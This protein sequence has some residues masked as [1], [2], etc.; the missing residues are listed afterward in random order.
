[1]KTLS[2]MFNSQP[3]IAVSGAGAAVPRGQD[4]ARSLARPHRDVRSG[5]ITR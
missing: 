3:L 4:R 5:E 2:R 1:M